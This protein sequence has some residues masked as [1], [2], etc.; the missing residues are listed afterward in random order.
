MIPERLSHATGGPSRNCNVISCWG[1]AG[2]MTTQRDLV[3]QEGN[4]VDM[5]KGPEIRDDTVLEAEIG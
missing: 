5:Q 4:G 2:S 1:G 3:C